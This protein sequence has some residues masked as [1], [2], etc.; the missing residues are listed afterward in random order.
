MTEKNFIEREFPLFPHA[1]WKNEK[2]TLTEI[3]FRQINSLV[4]CLVN[5]L[6]SRNFVL[7]FREIN[8]F[9]NQLY[10]KLIWQKKITWT[11]VI[12][13]DINFFSNFFSR[14]VANMIFFKWMKLSSSS[15]SYFLR[16]QNHAIVS[17]EICNTIDLL[18]L[19]A[20]FSSFCHL[21]PNFFCGRP[22]RLASK[23]RQ[24]RGH[25]CCSPFLKRI[26]PR[27]ILWSCPN[28]Y[29]GFASGHKWSWWGQWKA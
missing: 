10:S 7:K 17:I 26:R 27:H 18:F 2:F 13:R 1:L 3:F 22:H 25:Y 8:C 6:L 15:I 4:I 23:T 21:L 11:W 24:I 29:R 12:F 9:T 28:W 5:A 20:F 16:W 14:I 19:K